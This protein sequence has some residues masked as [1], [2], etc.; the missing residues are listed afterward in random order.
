MRKWLA[1]ALA[2]VLILGGA[3]VARSIQTSGGAVT[4]TEVTMPGE[5]GITL[6]GLLYTPKTATAA[7]PAP[8]VLVSHGYINTREMQSPFAIELSRRGFVVLAMDMTGHGYS[9]GIVG[10]PGGFGGPAALRYLKGLPQVD[11]ANIGLEGHSMGGG[12]V[13]AAAV[14]DPE[15]YKSIVLAGSTPRLLPGAAAP[16]NPKN[17]AVVFGQFDEFAPLM[18]GVPKGSDIATSKKLA[19]VFGVPG[20]VEV[21]KV[22]GDIAAGTARRLT[23]PRVTHPWEHFSQAGIG[24]TVD[25]FQQTLPA[26]A[27]KPPTDQVWLTKEI[28]TLVSFIGMVGLILAT[29]DLLLAFGPFKALAEP[30][31]PVVEARNGRW[32]LSLLI[33]AALPAVTYFPLM[34]VGQVFFPMAPFPQWIQNQLLV[35]ALGNAI[36]ILL[37]GLVLRSKP[38]FSN[39]WALSAAA[40]VVTMAVAYLSLVIVDAAFKTDYRF[41]VLGLKPLSLARAAELPAYLVLWTLFF[42]VAIR[43]LCANIAVKGE[44]YIAAIGWAKIAM[45]MGFAVLVIWEYTTLFTTGL[46]A[47]GPTTAL[48]VIVAIQFVPLLGVIGIIGMTTYRRT[49]S[50]VPGALICALLISWYV[51]SGTANHWAPGFKPQLPGASARR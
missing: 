9:G 39:R 50:Y 4:V 2:W 12:P 24:D 5:Q 41:W 36:L 27:A 23:N 29:F 22:Y 15:G 35:W 1:F 43:S 7:T 30:A 42:L 46:L 38:V 14:A 48:N 44:G 26:P 13:M 10:Q 11:K 34:N 28:G 33:S 3:W 16:E 25:W 32:W 8:G 45:A 18:W 6:S 49:N 51:T 47:T 20:P 21:G 40:A 19:K 37:I 31:Q 17:L